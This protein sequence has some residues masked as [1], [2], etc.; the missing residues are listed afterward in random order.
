LIQRIRVKRAHFGLLGGLSAAIDGTPCRP[1]Q[2]VAFGGCHYGSSS[3]Y[4]RHGKNNK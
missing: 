3:V 4:G 2:V 1:G